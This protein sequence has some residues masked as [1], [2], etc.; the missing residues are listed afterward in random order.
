MVF[1]PAYFHPQLMNSA[2]N[3]QF[4][5]FMFAKSRCGP[6]LGPCALFRPDLQATAGKTLS[7]GTTEQVPLMTHMYGFI[8]FNLKHCEPTSP[9]TQNL[10]L[11]TLLR[12][13]NERELRKETKDKINLRC[14]TIK[15][16]SLILNSKH[17]GL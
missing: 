13:S 11:E 4:S 17:W 6:P 2:L 16:R 12:D 5:A 15:K 10:Y 14:T 8:S 7:A 1:L 9:P 3:P